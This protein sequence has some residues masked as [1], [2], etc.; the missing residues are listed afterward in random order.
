MTEHCLHQFVGGTVVLLWA[1]GVMLRKGV[2]AGQ[3]NPLVVGTKC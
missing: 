1:M 2:G 3:T